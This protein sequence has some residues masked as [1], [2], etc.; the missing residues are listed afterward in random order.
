MK[1]SSFNLAVI[2]L[3][4]SAML[5]VVSC[6]RSDDPAPDCPSVTYTGQIRIIFQAKC[7]GGACHPANGDL[8]TYTGA[9]NIRSQIKTR[10]QNGTMPPPGSFI[11]TAEEKRLIACWV[12]QGA[13]EN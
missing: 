11:L 5:S 2:S 8:F 9:F 10:T 4:V 3:S 1:K 12:D 13:L 7:Q 6:T